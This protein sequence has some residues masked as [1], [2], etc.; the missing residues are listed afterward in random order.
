MAEW[1]WLWCDG[2]VRRRPGTAPVA[3][4]L[5]SRLLTVA[6]T[7]SSE[8]N[9]DWTAAP[10]LAP[11]SLYSA[12]R[13][14]FTF[15]SGRH[16]ARIGPEWRC[17]ANPGLQSGQ[18]RAHT[19][20]AQARSPLAPTRAGRLG[21]RKSRLK[22]TAHSLTAVCRLDPDNRCCALADNA[23]LGTLTCGRLRRRRCPPTTWPIPT[24][25]DSAESVRL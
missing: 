4:V 5:A 15:G 19:G 18:A 14:V 16:R 12:T 20:F 11:E 7:R 13:A 25:L 23:Y 1:G 21:V 2:G 17:K 6:P 22:G 9:Y 24:R 3:Q 8:H 10:P